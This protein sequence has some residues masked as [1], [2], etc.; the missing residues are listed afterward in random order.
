MTLGAKKLDRYVLPIFPALGV[1]AALG[2]AAAYGWLRDQM[3]AATAWQPSAMIPLAGHGRRAGRRAGGL[4]GRR[5]VSVLPVVLQPAARRRAGGAADRDGRE[6]RGAGPGGGLAERAAGRRRSLGRLA[7]VRHPPGADRGVR[8]AAARPGAVERRLRGAVPLPD[9]DR[10]QSAR[11]GR[12]PEPPDARARRLDQRR[13]ST[14]GS[15]A[16]RT[17]WRRRAAAACW[18]RR[19]AISRAGGGRGN[20]AAG[21]S[22]WRRSSGAAGRTSSG[23]GCGGCG[24]SRR[25]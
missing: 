10:A 8:R 23:F 21:C 7:L 14:R 18:P 2:L 1:L 20:H 6:R 24:R 13:S 16:G 5:D 4:A 22:G 25:A 9:P 3:A 17:S 11:P 12:V 19:G 15:I